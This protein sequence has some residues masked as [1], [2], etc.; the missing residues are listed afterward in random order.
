MPMQGNTLSSGPTDQ[1]IAM[2]RRIARP[3]RAAL[4][5]YALALTIATH[6]P[7]L[8]I[9]R[10]A[11]PASDKMI[12]AI[13]FAGLAWLL[14]RSRWFGS[15]WLVVLIALLWCAA[16]EFSQGI[17]ILGRQSSRYDLTASALGVITAGVW[18]WAL[19]PIGGVANRMRL[20]LDQSAFDRLFLSRRVW[21][22]FIGVLLI[23][24]V[25]P[26]IAWL[27]LSPVIVSR[28]IVLCAGIWLVASVTELAPPVAFTA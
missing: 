9:S 24:A 15:R 7:R 2:A 21:M 12:H 25:P 17:P 16:D 3:W 13:A 22:I 5:I 23:C 1:A 19:G 28:L 8:E 4:V 11:M 20:A 18:L 14:W 10:E 6:W 27:I 26:S